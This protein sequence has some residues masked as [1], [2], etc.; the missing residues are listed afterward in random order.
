MYE[1]SNSY[2]LVKSAEDTGFSAYANGSVA[3]ETFS[4]DEDGVASSW[5]TIIQHCFTFSFGPLIFLL[6][7]SVHRHSFLIEGLNCSPCKRDQ[8]CA[9]WTG[10]SNVSLRFFSSPSAHFLQIPF[11]QILRSAPPTSS[12]RAVCLLHTLLY[13]SVRPRLKDLA[14]SV[15][16]VWS[17]E[18]SHLLYISIRSKC[19]VLVSD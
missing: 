7:T 2:D 18:C 17:S 11:L 1:E 19:F 6:I 9:S 8:C 5:I 12:W 15:S 14:S 13:R 16:L 4:L 3:E 10:S